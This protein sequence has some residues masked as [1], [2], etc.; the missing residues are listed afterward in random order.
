MQND[1][2]CS[3]EFRKCRTLLS[4]CVCQLSPRVLGNMEYSKLD[5]TPYSLNK[6]FPPNNPTGHY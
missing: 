5:K 3:Q 6:A 2:C 1:I 4:M